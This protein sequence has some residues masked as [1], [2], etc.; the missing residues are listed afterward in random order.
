[1]DEVFC[2]VDFSIALTWWEEGADS[3]DIVMG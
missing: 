1:M 2:Y 3:H